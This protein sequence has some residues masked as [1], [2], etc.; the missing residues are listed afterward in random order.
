MY[1][2][3]VQHEPIFHLPVSE[4]KSDW[5]SLSD[6]EIRV[7]FYRNSRDFDSDSTNIGRIANLK[8]GGERA[9]KT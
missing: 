5:Y 8:A 7:D 2:Y 6:C 9:A 1:T 3:I 4:L